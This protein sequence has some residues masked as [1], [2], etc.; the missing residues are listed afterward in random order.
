MKEYDL[1]I[2]LVYSETINS[3][4]NLLASKRNKP[5]NDSEEYR[6]SLGT[7]SCKGPTWVD[8][9]LRPRLLVLQVRPHGYRYTMS[10]THDAIAPF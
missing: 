1:F 6:R 3:S 4:S 9:R 10:G 7:T 2:L 8:A 5:I